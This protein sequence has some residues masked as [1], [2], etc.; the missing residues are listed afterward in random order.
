MQK[1]HESTDA[2]NPELQPLSNFKLILVSK[3]SNMIEFAKEKIENYD[4]DSGN[5]YYQFT[6]SNEEYISP[7]TKVV[8][9]HEVSEYACNIDANIMHA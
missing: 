8:L 5:G 6:E 7:K 3:E 1:H 2:A 9:V 4:P